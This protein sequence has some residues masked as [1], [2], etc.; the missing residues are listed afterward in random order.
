M[1]STTTIRRL[2]F[3]ILTTSMLFSTRIEAQ[4]SA[5]H[6]RGKL[7]ETLFNRGFIGHP[8]AW[9]YE[10][11]T[12]IGFYPGFFGFSFPDHEEHVVYWPKVD[13]NFHNFRSGPWLIVKNAKTLV[14]PDYHPEPRDFL[15]YHSSMVIHPGK[16]A[17]HLWNNPPFEIT[18]NFIGTATY[19]PLFPEEINYSW[20]HTATGITVK[21]RS[22][23]WSFPNYD[24]FIIYDYIFVN[25]G[26]VALPA[27]NRTEHYEQKLNE[28]WIVFHSG[29]QVSTK[30]FLNFHWDENFLTSVAPAGGFGG[31]RASEPDKGG[32]SDF[33]AIENYSLTNNVPDGKGLLYYSRDYNGGREPLPT[34]MDPYKPRK[35]WEAFVRLKP[36]WL[37]E[38]QDP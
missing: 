34:S 36:N 21:Q 35:N 11:I 5:T 2:I 24:D 15:L 30:G 1:K 38:L 32:F 10:E 20:F 29:L 25:T 3:A 26:E 12:G 23:A 8:G 14:P 17:G 16:D 18:R 19:N 7:W 33:Y 28:V 22:I 37:P 9:D 13:A 6:T 4:I 31:W 27:V